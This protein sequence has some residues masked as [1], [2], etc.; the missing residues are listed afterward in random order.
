MRLA[1]F[2]LRRVDLTTSKDRRQ[3]AK[4]FGGLGIVRL[5]LRTSVLVEGCSLFVDK[6]GAHRH[7]NLAVVLDAQDLDIDLRSHGKLLREVGTL[8]VKRRFS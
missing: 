8:G 2:A 1:S 6:Q 5:L 7:A 4:A 3:R